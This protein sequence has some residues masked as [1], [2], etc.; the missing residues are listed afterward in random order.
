M[1]TSF[2]RAQERD[3]KNRREHRAHIK[4]HRVHRGVEERHPRA[5]GQTHF[6]VHRPHPRRR[7]PI[8]RNCEAVVKKCHDRKQRRQDEERKSEGQN[9][10][11]KPEREGKDRDENEVENKRDDPPR[12]NAPAGR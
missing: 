12:A 10:E 9:G 1:Q 8:T 2:V 7:H 11:R 6:E 3:E 4:E 5:I